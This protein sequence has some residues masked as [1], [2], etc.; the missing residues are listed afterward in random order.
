[1]KCACHVPLSNAVARPQVPLAHLMR[2]H[3]NAR[4]KSSTRCFRALPCACV[5]LRSERV[6]RE[7]GRVQRPSDRWWLRHDDQ[8]LAAFFTN[9]GMT[10]HG[11]L[12]M[13]ALRSATACLI[14]THTQDAA[15][16]ARSARA[17]GVGSVLGG[18]ITANMPDDV[19]M[20]QPAEP[21]QLH[22]HTRRVVLM[23]THPFVH[24]W[25]QFANATYEEREALYAMSRSP[26]YPLITRCAERVVGGEADLIMGL[27]ERLTFW[28]LN[29]SHPERCHSWTF[30]PAISLS[31]ANPKQLFLAMNRSVGEPIFHGIQASL[32]WLRQVPH[33]ARNLQEPHAS[34]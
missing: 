30:A 3:L 13:T 23:H 7:R 12:D 33:A 18:L 15:E 26:E 34:G 22:T 25:A 11:P 8:N 24:L 27:R 5:R 10:V 31:R 2:P 21:C 19:Q 1:M 6:C 16:A 29:R 4:S 14:E 17:Y 32:A 20:T 28:L 9:D